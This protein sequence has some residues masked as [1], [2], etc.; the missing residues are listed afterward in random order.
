MIYLIHLERRY[1]HA[2]HYRGWTGGPLAYRVGHHKRGTGAN[3]L[4]VANDAGIRWAVVR[5]WK[6]GTRADERRMKQSH[7]ATR[8]C[9]VCNG[10]A[11]VCWDCG[12]VYRYPGW[13]RRHQSIAHQETEAEAA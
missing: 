5:V 2:G 1:K 7:S 10:T 13:L 12:K 8:D 3:F 11:H 9:P 6:D 4:R